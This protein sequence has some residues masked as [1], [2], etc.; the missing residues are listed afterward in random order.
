MG[1][2]HSI[3]CEVCGQ[4]RG[5]INDYVCK[6]DRNGAISRWETYLRFETLAANLATAGGLAKSFWLGREYVDYVT[7]LFEGHADDQS[8]P[9]H[10][11]CNRPAPGWEE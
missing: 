5:G 10:P 8:D 11:G 4:L 2:D 7:D 6:C 1:R 9:W 3:E